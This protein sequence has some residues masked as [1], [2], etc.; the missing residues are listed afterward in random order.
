MA[1]VTYGHVFYQL[2]SLSVETKILKDLSHTHTRTNAH[3][4]SHMPFLIFYVIKFHV[5][6][7]L[8]CEIVTINIFTQSMHKES[9]SYLQV[10]DRPEYTRP[11]WPTVYKRGPDSM[12]YCLI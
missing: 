8:A 12:L 7:C 4:H 2:C 3:S 5:D 11:H 9:V 1:L 10:K 6:D